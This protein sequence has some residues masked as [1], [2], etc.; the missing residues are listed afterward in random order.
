MGFN[1]SILNI[2]LENHVS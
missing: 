2:V 1:Y